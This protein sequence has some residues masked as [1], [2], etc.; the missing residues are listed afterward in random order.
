MTE[1]QES[2]AARKLKPL[3]YH[4]RIRDYL[5][6]EEPQVWNWYASHRVRN[7]QADAVRF[8]LLKS[9][10]RVERETQSELYAAAE[11]VADKLSLPVPITIYQAQNPAGLNASLACLPDEAHIVLHGPIAAKLS[12]LEI[13]ALL[14]H[15]LSHLF[16]WREWQGEFLIVDQILS[17]MTRDAR[18]DMPHFATARLVQLVTEIFCDRG[19]LFVVEDPMV[20]VSML[21][22][23]QTELEEVSPE[24]YL[25]QAEEIFSRGQPKSDQATHP[26][27][28]IRAR[29]IKI[30]SDG[31][32][33][34]DAQTERMVAG[35]PSLDGL[36]FLNQQKVARWT[37]KLIDALL[38]PKWM[39]TESVLAHARLFFEDYSPPEG[40]TAVELLAEEIR[41]DDEPMLD[42]YCYILLDFVSADRELEE[43]PLAAAL[44]LSET[45][46]LK[47]RFAEIARKELRLRKRQFE[48]I[49]REKRELLKRQEN[50]SV[51]RV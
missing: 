12:D 10:Y 38:A 8:E 51:H 9:T 31:D 45:L 36:D 30:W 23:V 21:I 22:K 47:E 41:T 28:F 1:T 7:D 13:R 4:E 15:E 42:Y 25:R 37:R 49:D 5:K 26:E 6:A 14:A 27:A 39:Q 19:S 43:L 33:D 34:A 46:G 35:K 18:A 40:D 48:K 11:Q 32:P 29:A 16:L 3:P 20:V 44:A 24:S 17:A 2:I 50:D